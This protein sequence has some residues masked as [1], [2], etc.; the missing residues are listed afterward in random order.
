M[1]LKNRDAD[2]G[3]PNMNV[4]HS[5]DEIDKHKTEHVYDEIK[6]NNVELEYDHLDYTRAQSDRKPH[7]QI[8][9]NSFG[10]VPRD[11]GGPSRSLDRNDVED[12]KT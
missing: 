9:A 12:G 6:P 11:S 3:N 4:Y 10:T 2:S 1:A 5:I 8:M 7:Y